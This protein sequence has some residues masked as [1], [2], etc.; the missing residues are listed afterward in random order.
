M[1][2]RAIYDIEGNGLLIP[3]LS[4]CKTILHPPVSIIWCIVIYDCQTR[5]Y[6][7]YGPDQVED[8][9]HK[10][11]EYDIIIAHNGIGYDKP[12]LEK[13]LGHLGDLPQQGDTYIMSR[14]LWGPQDSPTPSGKHGMEAWGEFFG[15]EKIEFS[16]FSFW[17]EEMLDYCV[18]DVEINVSTYNY[19]AP[20]MTKDLLPAYQQEC[21]TT[22]LFVKQMLTGIHIDL[23]AH[24]ALM[25]QL[26]I[27][28]AEAADKLSHINPPGNTTY[29]KTPEYYIDPA[30]DLR[31]RI[32][33]DAPNSIRSTLVDGPLK[34]KVKPFNPNSTTQIGDYLTNVL[35]YKPKV[36]TEAG[37]PSFGADVL[38]N[39]PYPEVEALGEYRI[40]A[41]RLSQCEAWLRYTTDEG[42]IHGSING[43]GA[44]TYRCTHKNPNLANVP[45]ARKPFGKEC[46][47]V[48]TAP[49]G[50][51]LTGVDAKGLELRCLANGLY[52]FDGGKYMELVLSGEV[53]K[54]NQSILEVP[55]VDE[56]KTAIYAFN[57]GAGILKLGKIAKHSPGI[58]EEAKSVTLMP[59][60]IKYLEE[61]GWLNEE[62]VLYAKMGMIVRKR[63]YA[64]TEGLTDFVDSLKAEYDNQ[65]YLTGIDGR[66][67]PVEREHTILNRR[68]QSDGGILMKYALNINYNDISAAGYI[69]DDDWAYA[70]NIHDEFQEWHDASETEFFQHT[71]KNAI[72]KA[73][74]HLGMVC[75]LEGSADTGINWSLT[76]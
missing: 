16:E 44:A 36:Y 69:Y 21:M 6:H 76:H 73:G 37:N 23:D 19:I 65:G 22:R 15:R 64:D 61:N 59:M 17:Q 35:G 7:K 70:L 2:K 32:K 54:R 53:H 25:Q 38:E 50:K 52:A 58:Q 8:G 33:G 43:I 13:V 28:L 10:L 14:L 4:K 46:R 55:T 68:L 20:R 39:L 27:A 66:R 40:A 67:I 30:T 9:Y 51:V 62:N 34:K 47:A 48:F 26:H 71:G 3:T 24:S 31:Y 49:P 74:V 18:R 11:Q 56:A 60:Y 1:L 42:K 63:L 45:A 72:T 57:Y 12:A 29:L 75:P 5:Q 41:D